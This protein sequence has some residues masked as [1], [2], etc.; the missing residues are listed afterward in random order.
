MFTEQGDCR[1]RKRRGEVLATQQKKR[2]AGVGT[3]A[4]VMRAPPMMAAEQKPLKATGSIGFH[5]CFVLYVNLNQ[6]NGCPEVAGFLIKL[7]RIDRS[8]KRVVK[9]SSQ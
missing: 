2:A 3:S 5:N 6:C 1:E 9:P 4:G 8:D 7:A